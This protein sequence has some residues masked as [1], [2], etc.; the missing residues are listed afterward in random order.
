[1][2]HAKAA[3]PTRRSCPVRKNS[4]AHLRAAPPH[5]PCQ[6]PRAI[7]ALL[8]APAAA[9]ASKR[10][11]LRNRRAAACRVQSRGHVQF[12]G[13]DAPR[14][15]HAQQARGATGNS[16]CKK[17]LALA[18]L[19]KPVCTWSCHADCANRSNCHRSWPWPPGFPTDLRIF[20]LAGCGKVRWGSS[21]DCQRRSWD[22]P[23][24]P[25]GL[26]ALEAPT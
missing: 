5:I 18:L 10:A 25:S 4:T 15:S 11:N 1:M 23:L 16:I 13:A 21:N 24:R 20:A 19:I 22:E 7:Q 9:G 17:S 3:L 8:E 12:P 14:I 2:D 6:L 26:P